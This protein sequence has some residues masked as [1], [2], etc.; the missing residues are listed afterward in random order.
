MNTTRGNNG[1]SPL[2]VLDNQVFLYIRAQKKR[3][4][5]Y[6]KKAPKPSTMEK[7]LHTTLFIK[8]LIALP[9]FLIKKMERNMEAF[10]VFVD[11]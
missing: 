10:A 11:Y 6:G 3:N 7:I 5:L 1:S 4:F 8:D 2:N 9:D